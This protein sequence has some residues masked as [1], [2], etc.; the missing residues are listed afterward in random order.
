MLPCVELSS[1]AASVII[2]FTM[3]PR[4][5]FRLPLRWEISPM[6]KGL[7]RQI[8]WIWRAYK[9]TGDLAMESKKNFE[10][11]SECVEDARQNGYV[12][13]EDS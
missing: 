7:D 1:V 5:P 2:P 3:A 9:Q 13:P 10:S 6:Y 12:S 8:A 4:D 11:F